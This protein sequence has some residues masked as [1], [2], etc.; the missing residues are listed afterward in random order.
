VDSL[1][2]A[3]QSFGDLKKLQGDLDD[4]F[5]RSKLRYLSIKPQVLNIGPV[6]V[7]RLTPGAAA[8]LPVLMEVMNGVA[9]ADAAAVAAQARAVEQAYRGDPLV[10]TAL[11]EAEL[12]ANNFAAAEAAADR[13]MAVDPQSTDAMILKGESKIEELAKSGAPA[14]AFADARSWFLKANKIDP[15]DPEPLYEFYDSFEREGIAPTAN[16][17]AALH[18][19]SDLAPQDGGVRLT[20]AGQYLLEGKPKDARAALI[21]VAYDPHGGETAAMARK[22]IQHIDAGD[23]NGALKEAGW[24]LHSRSGS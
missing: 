17:I 4:Y 3:R 22:M 14:A 24:T 13:A 20:S 7:S 16:A 23:S 5:N 2:A 1:E 10:E 15:E 21:P 12:A 6:E 11:G 19:A 8:A 18:Y 9:K